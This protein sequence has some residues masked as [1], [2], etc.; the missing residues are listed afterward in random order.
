MIN[1][2]QF[3]PFSAC[4]SVFFYY[5]SVL[6]CASSASSA[7]SGDGNVCEVRLRVRGRTFCRDRRLRAIARAA[8][9]CAGLA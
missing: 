9:D 5:S 4:I 8:A 6:G 3:V 7:S 2:E 1:K